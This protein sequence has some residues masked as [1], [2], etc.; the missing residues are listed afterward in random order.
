MTPVKI[1]ILPLS[2]AL[3]FAIASCGSAQENG[4]QERDAVQFAMRNVMYHY[5]ES[6]AAHIIHLEGELLSTKPG[7]I[8]VFDDKNSFELSV[9]SAEISISCASLAK[10][11][12]EN[13]LAVRDAPVKNLSITATNGHLLVKGKFRRGADLPFEASG[14]LS[15]DSSGKIRLHTEHVKALHLPVK[16]LMDLLGVDLA[17]MINSNKV[18]GLSAEK[19]DLLIDPGQI[20]PPPRLRGKVSSVRI[21]GNN[22]VQEFGSPAKSFAAAER[23]NYMAFRHGDIRFGK[24]TMHDADLIMIDLDTIDPFDFFL[25]HYQDQLVAGYTKSTPEFGLRTYVRDYRK[26]PKQRTKD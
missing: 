16:G 21:E 10:L 5:T 18:H 23:G 9:A 25:D 12:N 7:S 1:R 13:V 17:E 3:F 22:I 11:L 26:L 15:A 2:V 20:L 6:T 19:D 4:S 8:V 14:T 24:L